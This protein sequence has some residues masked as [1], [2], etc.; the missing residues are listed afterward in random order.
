MK[1]TFTQTM[2]IIKRMSKALD[3]FRTFAQ[4]DHGKSLFQVVP[5][6]RKTLVLLDE[7]FKAHDIAV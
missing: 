1:A 7:T 4:P 5:L 3:D 6:V 2:D